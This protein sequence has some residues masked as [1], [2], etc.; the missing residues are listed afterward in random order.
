M[1][2]RCKNA[3]RRRSSNVKKTAPLVTCTKVEQRSVIRFLSSEG[4][5]TIEI[6]RQMKVECG[7][8]CHYRKCTSGLGTS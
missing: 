1:A 6:H 8:G 4:V 7:D 2:V 3:T 5:K